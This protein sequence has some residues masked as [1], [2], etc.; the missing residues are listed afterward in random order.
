[1]TNETLPKLPNGAGSAAILAAGLASFM[2]AVLAII[3]DHASTFKKL[4]IFYTPTGPLSGVT[5]TAIAIWLLS[6]V[7][8]DIA[9]RRRNVN[10]VIVPAGLCLLTIGFLLMVPLIGDLF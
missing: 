7:V 5:T 1:M 3:A 10:E 9:W 8:L 4:M 6:W 2:M